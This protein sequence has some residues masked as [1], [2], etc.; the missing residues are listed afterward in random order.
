NAGLAWCFAINAVS[1][2]TVLTG[3][4]RVSLPPS[5]RVRREATLHEGVR[6][7]LA[8]IRDQRTMRALVAVITVFS[9]LAVPVV[10]LMPVVARDLFRTGSSGY[11]VLLSAIGVGGMLA[12]L[13]IAGPGSHWRHGRL[14]VRASH[15]AAVLLIVLP[16][17]HVWLLGWL[18]L[19]GVGFCFIANNA[20]SNV[21]LQVLVPDELRGRV[22]SVYGL[23]VVGLAQVVGASLGGA[24]AQLF[25]VGWAIGGAAG[26][27]LLYLLIA[28]RQYPELREL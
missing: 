21:L 14:L 15:I 4:A 19:F 17:V 9:V 26:V 2:L 27:L 20:A 12:A 18:L 28:F 10:S 7:V 24:I 3:L 8:Y 6:E 5:E 13:V 22:M 23:I 11:G 16:F 1:F 25:G